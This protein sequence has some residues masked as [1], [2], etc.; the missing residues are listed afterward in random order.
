MHCATL[1]FFL[2]ELKQL[3]SSRV[4]R[5]GTNAPLLSTAACRSSTA[6]PILKRAN[7]VFWQGMT[8]TLDTQTIAVGLLVA[9]I[10]FSILRP[11][12]RFPKP[13]PPSPKGLPLVGH[14]LLMSG[15][16]YSWKKFDDL[17]QSIGRPPVMYMRLG[18][19]DALVISTCKGRQ[20]PPQPACCCPSNACSHWGNRF[21]ARVETAVA[22]D[23][24]MCACSCT[25]SAR[26][27]KCHLL[28]PSTHDRT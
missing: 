26:T 21:R 9:V 1:S 14:T 22:A 15:V 16:K 5:Q 23:L 8:I 13:L 11:R 24:L 6:P 4:K 25:R 28:R 3:S 10:V 12:A 18:T 20:G 2:Y 17:Q 7:A 19:S 27:Q